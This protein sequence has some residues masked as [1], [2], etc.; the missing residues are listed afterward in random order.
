MIAVL[1]I[2]LIKDMINNNI[3]SSTTRNL[4]DEFDKLFGFDTNSF[5]EWLL[6]AV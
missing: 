3:I 4:S 2:K 6:S 1:T 5:D